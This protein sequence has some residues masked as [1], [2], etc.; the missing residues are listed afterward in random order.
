M[1]IYM[2]NIF[3]TS[4]SPRLCAKLHEQKTRTRMNENYSKENPEALLIPL[5]RS[6]A[7]QG[8]APPLR[9]TSSL[10]YAPFIELMPWHH[11]FVRAFHRQQGSS[12]RHVQHTIA[13]SLTTPKPRGLSPWR[14]LWMIQSYLGERGYTTPTAGTQQSLASSRAPEPPFQIVPSKRALYVDPPSLFPSLEGLS[15]DNSRPVARFRMACYHSREL[16]ALA[17]ASSLDTDRTRN[18]QRTRAHFYL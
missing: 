9:P 6:L 2:R 13:T 11:S 8:S 1:Q 15:S 18:A 3:A 4:V 16:P 10:L 12:P 7:P 17:Y 14:L 5:I